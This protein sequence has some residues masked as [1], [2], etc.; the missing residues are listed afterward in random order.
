MCDGRWAI[1]D[2][3]RSLIYRSF[4]PKLAPAEV[5]ASEGWSGVRESNPPSWLGKPEHYH[6]AN[7]AKLNNSPF[8]QRAVNF[9]LALLEKRATRPH[10]SAV[11][12]IYEPIVSNANELA[13]IQ[14]DASEIL[15]KQTVNPQT[16]SCRLLQRVDTLGFMIVNEMV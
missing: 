11:G 2:A 14:L 4:A 13:F 5:Q 8:C 12:S 1:G 16:T 6:Y 15:T 3:Y 7:P 9:T 10:G